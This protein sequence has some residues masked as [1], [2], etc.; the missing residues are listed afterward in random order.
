MSLKYC[1]A[2]NE[3]AC[4]QDNKIGKAATRLNEAEV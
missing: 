1:F 3:V 4:L 2:N